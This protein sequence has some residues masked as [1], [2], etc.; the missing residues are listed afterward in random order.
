MD[1]LD[2][3]HRRFDY[4]EERVLEILDLRQTSGTYYNYSS[5]FPTKTAPMPRSPADFSF[6]NNEGDDTT[7]FSFGEIDENV[8]I[9]NTAQTGDSEEFEAFLESQNIK[10]IDE[11]P[12][13][14]D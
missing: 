10:L 13:F 6:S 8:V 11:S 14:I 1:R 9:G 3:R 4:L 7:T 12:N 5:A 2:E